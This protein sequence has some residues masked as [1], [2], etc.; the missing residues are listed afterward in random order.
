M[1]PDLAQALLDN[2]SFDAGTPLFVPGYYSNCS[3]RNW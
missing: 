3:T 2:G 1:G